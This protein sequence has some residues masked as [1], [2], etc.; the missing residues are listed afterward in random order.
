MCS[1]SHVFDAH[2]S[3]K[4]S[5]MRASYLSELGLIYW[6]GGSLVEIN[7]YSYLNSQAKC[8]EHDEHKH[9]VLKPSGV[10]HVPELVLVWVLRDVPPQRTSLESV[11]YA[12]TLHRK[13]TKTHLVFWLSQVCTKPILKAT[14]THILSVPTHLACCCWYWPGSCPVHS[15]CTPSL[16]VPE[17]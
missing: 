15:F 3:L 7:S 10:H 14:H 13:K 4:L 2:I 1:W 12:L 11:L 9:D 8:V 17:M 5:F 16:L 6:I